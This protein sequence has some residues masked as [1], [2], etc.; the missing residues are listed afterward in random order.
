MEG[1]FNLLSQCSSAWDWGFKPAVHQAA[2]LLALLC[3]T[4]LARPRSFSHSRLPATQPAYAMFE[5]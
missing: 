5:Y 4:L 2:C 3:F 1:W